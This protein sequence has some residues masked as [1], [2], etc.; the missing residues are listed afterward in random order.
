M[1]NSVN[2][3]IKGIVSDLSPIDI[4]NQHWV[5]PTVN[6]RITKSG[7]Q[8]IAKPV[9]GN[10][11]LFEIPVGYKIIGAK[12]YSDIVYFVLFNDS[13]G[14]VEIG[15]YPYIDNTGTYVHEYRAL[16]CL[17][18]TDKS[19]RTN[20]LGFDS[21]KVDIQ[22]AES[23]DGTIDLYLNDSRT[24]T[25]KINSNM[26]PSG[27]LNNLI[28][29]T[30]LPYSAYLISD[31]S[32]PMTIDSLVLEQGG[33]L[34]PGKTTIFIRYSTKNFNKTTFIVQSEPI[35]VHGT[36]NSLYKAGSFLL[37]EDMPELVNASLK[38]N[39]SNID[40]SFDFYQIGVVVASANNDEVAK[41]TAYLISQYFPTSQT[42][43]VIDGYETR[44][45]LSINDIGATSFSDNINKAQTI[46]DNKYIGANWESRGYNK[47]NLATYSA[48][49]TVDS[50]SFPSRSNEKTTYYPGEIYPFGIIY[51]FADGRE[52]EVFPIQGYDMVNS[53]NMEKGLVQFP[54][55]VTG[56]VINSFGIK[57]NLSAFNDAI[58]NEEDII[59]YT[60]VRGDRIKNILANGIALGMIN[61]TNF[62]NLN[63]SGDSEIQVMAL[64]YGSATA[65]T[66]APEYFYSKNE[67]GA[68]A[69]PD[70]FDGNYPTYKTDDNDKIGFAYDT[71][72]DPIFYPDP[73]EA[74]TNQI[75]FYSPD[76]SMSNHFNN[77]D[78]ENVY[79]SKVNSLATSPTKIETEDPT[80]FNV[81]SAHK[82]YNQFKFENNYINQLTSTGLTIN[83]TFVEKGRKRVAGLFS[84]FLPDYTVDPDIPWTRRRYIVKDETWKLYPRSS[85][86]GKYIGLSSDAD[87]SSLINQNL[88]I[89][90]YQTL[91]DYKTSVLDNFQLRSQIY[92]KITQFIAKN[93]VST[94]DVFGGDSYKG[95]VFLRGVKWFGAKNL[96]ETYTS[97]KYVYHHGT[98]LSFNA[99]S[100]VNF[101]MRSEVKSEDPS[102]TLGKYSF[103]PRASL[104]NT[105]EG[106]N[107]LSS[108]E[109]DMHESISINDGYNKS[110]SIKGYL[111]YDDVSPLSV[112]K[113]PS[114]IRSSATRVKG[115]YY[116]GFK[117]FYADDSVDVSERYGS[118]VGVY[119]LYGMLMIVQ[120]KAIS[121]VYTNV[122]SVASDGSFDIVTGSSRSYLYDKPYVKTSYG[123]QSRDHILATEKG[124]Y[125]IDVDSKI[126]WFAFSG[127]TNEGKQ[128]SQIKDIGKEK[129]ITSYIFDLM[130]FLS[131]KEYDV[132]LGYD[133]FNREVLFTFKYSNSEAQYEN[134][135]ELNGYYYLT[136]VFSEDLNAFTGLYTVPSDYYIQYRT[137]L[138]SVSNTVNVHYRGSKQLNFFG[139]DYSM[140]LS[141]IVN[142]AEDAP[143]LVK[144]F[145]ESV[146]L[147]CPKQPLKNIKFETETQNSKIDPFVQE[148]K[149]WL[150]PV[151]NEFQ[152]E[153][154]IPTNENGGA[155]FD[156]DSVMKGFWLKITV[157]YE[158][159]EEFYLIHSNTLFNPINY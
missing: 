107:I 121:Q 90:K 3:F 77:M 97:S 58:A 89:T 85:L 7:E 82:L 50:S 75:A 26:S 4:T 149:F 93:S 67:D 151:Y 144:K 36:P 74:L 17:N 138:L 123:A 135:V 46:I 130:A 65:D 86:F 147:S 118:I 103:W 140:L 24:P 125:G 76:V 2:R 137:N 64:Y 114:R 94:I 25:L 105:L 73:S 63:T 39:L 116:D 14:N 56:V 66:H 148:E 43:V 69:I 31:A 91:A 80:I 101:K 29:E 119:N 27:D 153:I 38:L 9:S 128:I 88:V 79:V 110:L 126:I 23:Y 134:A 47:E 61:N 108:N 129:L 37:D 42:S 51:R 120:N 1:S 78:L 28:D 139:K 33:N 62:R 156:S 111:G 18:A 112:N 84:S 44:E 158:G 40:E 30:K 146:K 12:E 41:H 22:F 8:F 55:N 5:F 53:V 109:E 13:D 96:Y 87:I 145:F 98:M 49:V 60:I 154:S 19:L 20:K 132:S 68:I 124:I 21:T 102:G 99:Y 57:F 34:E 113:Y 157:E 117:T 115:A 106:W 155:I 16:Q 71:N 136:I 6:M 104:R 92:S 32:I 142:S 133:K 141:Y 45:T 81:S 100:S 131:D 83:G 95:E 152:Y 70:F 72:D 15:S 143:Q 159:E 52:S 11:T 54:L 10:E 127:A 122:K 48:L 150:N 59:G 35:D